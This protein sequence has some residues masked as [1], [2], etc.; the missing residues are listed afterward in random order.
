[1]ISQSSSEANMSFVIDEAHLD[2]AVKA[3]Q[4]ELQKKT[5]ADVSCNSN[6]CVVAVVGAGMDGIPGVAGRIFGILGRE[7]INVIMISQGSSQHN[8]SFVINE[9]DAEK[10]VQHLNREFGL[11]TPPEE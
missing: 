6:I 10:A 11:G 9:K 2:I 5:I 8:I 3:L 4:S 7:K 1:M